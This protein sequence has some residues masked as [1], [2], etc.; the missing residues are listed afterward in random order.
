MVSSSS[1]A[2]LTVESI[3]TF[4]AVIGG[5][6]VFR[7]LWIEHKA[8]K[9]EFSDVNDFR[10]SKLR[11]NRGWKML[12][13]G[14][15]IETLVAGVFAAK[16]GWEVEKIRRNEAKTE[17]AVTN[18]PAKILQQEE[19]KYNGA[20]IPANEP[21][22]S[23]TVPSGWNPPDGTVALILGNSVSLAVWFPHTVILYKGKPA[24]TIST[25]S[26]GATLSADFFDMDGKI[27]AILENNEF[28][29]NPL[30]SFRLER[31]DKSTLRVR[32]Q[33]NVIVLDVRFLNPKAIK[34][35]GS[36]RFPGGREVLIDEKKG[37]F[38]N[39]N[40]FGA[41]VTDFVIP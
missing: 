21:V 22:P 19:E 37:V 26:Q 5:L 40:F 39:H 27:V 20:L 34:L 9:D 17:A 16:D 41:S 25:N 10:L 6:M 3:T 24:L 28:H 23:G 29:I 11:K 13:W 38:S 31:P 8:D 2:W 35:N 15:A 4:F 7:G 12:M 33:Q 18:L 30:N 32:D 1:L 36:L 14:I